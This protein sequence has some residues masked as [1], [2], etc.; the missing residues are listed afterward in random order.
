[1]Y[2]HLLKKRN[3]ISYFLLFWST[4]KA[5]YVDT[6][7][8]GYLKYVCICKFLKKREKCTSIY[9]T[10]KNYAREI[11]FSFKFRQK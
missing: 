4:T 5:N 8:N 3:L 2:F 10:L 1:M 6:E 11:F 7:K 9:S